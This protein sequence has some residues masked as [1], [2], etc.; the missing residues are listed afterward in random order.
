MGHTLL[1]THPIKYT[2]Y[3]CHMSVCL[4]PY[5]L[6]QKMNWHIWTSGWWNQGHETG[7]PKQ[8]SRYSACI[9]S[10]TWTNLNFFQYQAILELWPQYILLT[11]LPEFADSLWQEDG[12]QLWAISFLDNISLTRP[13]HNNIFLIVFYCYS[14]PYPAQGIWNGLLT[15]DAR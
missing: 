7:E 11:S 1:K 3:S 14:G 5:L 9:R 6:L 4:T 8:Q 15:T 2:L 13:A 10:L 12:Q